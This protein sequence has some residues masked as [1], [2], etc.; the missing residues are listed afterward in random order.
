MFQTISE[1]K[2]ILLETF[3]DQQFYQDLGMKILPNARW[4]TAFFLCPAKGGV[5]IR[6]RNIHCYGSRSHGTTSGR[7]WYNRNNEWV[8]GACGSA[9]KF[10]FIP[11][12]LLRSWDV[13]LG[14]LVESSYDVLRN[15]KL[16]V[17]LNQLKVR[18]PQLWCRCYLFDGLENGR[19]MSYFIPH[20]WAKAFI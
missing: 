6:H 3:L 16:L 19:Y 5:G 10:P 14:Q 13:N 11:L 2:Q 18:F 9:N 20:W 4:I 17:I 8:V 7:R 1:C 15:R 12:L